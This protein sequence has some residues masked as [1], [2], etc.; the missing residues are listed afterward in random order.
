MKLYLKKLFRNKVELLTNILIMILIL[1]FLLSYF[2]PSLLLSNT[3]TSGGD[4]AS[5][6][7]PAKYLKDYLLPKGKIIGWCPGWY[8][9]FPLFQ[10]YF[11]LPFLLMVFLSYVIPLQIAFKLVTVLGTFLLP[12]AAFFSMK[13]MK[14]KFPIPIIASTFTLPF[15]FMEANSMWGG[16]IPSTLAGEFSYSLSLALTVLFFGSLYKGIKSKKFLVANAIVFVLI[17]L[18]HI[19]TAIFAA[20][21]SIFFVLR[22][23]KRENFKYL[24]KL[25]IL[26]FLLLSFW[27][28]P[29]L[30]KRN[31]STI[32]HYVWVL[33]SLKSIF[34]EI[35]WPFFLLASFGVFL[36]SKGKDERILYLTFSLL[37]SILMYRLAPLVGLTDIRFIPFLQLFP[38]FIAS[39]TVA[40]LA[41]RI[42]TKWLLLLVILLLTLFWVKQNVNY[43]PSWIKWNYE[44]FEGKTA[45]SQFKEIN[46]YLSSL[47]PGRV[48]HEYSNSHNK[49]GTPRAF[50][51]V[52]LFADKPV[53][54]GLYIEA[55]LS[56]PFIFNIQSELSKTP[57]CPIPRLRCNAFSVENG[58]KHLKLF[59]VKYVIVTSDKLKTSIKENGE[60]VFLKRIDNIEIYKI[61]AS[62][63]VVLPKYE[64]IL[65]KTNDWKA[66]SLQW[67]KNLD[68]IDVPLVFMDN[69]KQEDYRRFK[70]V[71]D[72]LSNLTKIPVPQNCSI[73]E[74]VREEEV[75]IKTSCIDKPLIVK[76]SYFPNWQVEGA[77]KIYL[78]SP[79]FMLIFP[80]QE[81]VRLYYSYIYSDY[82]GLA[83]SLIGIF[84]IFYFKFL[85]KI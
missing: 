53:L 38:V 72:D 5:H 12:I 58:T 9:G 31:Y 64:P 42:K 41:K 55:A 47:P 14:F 81:N 37:V 46:D 29:L 28:V 62:G 44:G 76:I 22:K 7:Y 32:Y 23:K 66:V 57:T 78:A 45:Y 17:F 59:N 30:L 54:E 61:K 63:Y 1:C 65:F 50:E 11:F 43:I 82:L 20:V 36:A 49:F 80:K 51:S 33:D 52:P 60:Y 69:P 70:I 3:I 84:L 8:A 85:A 75:K 18:T 10:F 34:P 68:D 39:Y 2:K 26:S 71:S 24:F 25:Y 16:N 56:S 15:L 83:F 73:E 35:L 74:T 79:S 6:Y 13:L 27:L 40:E 21:S 67:F 19:Y 4:T 48:M 77:D